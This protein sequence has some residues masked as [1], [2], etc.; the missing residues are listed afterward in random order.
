MGLKLSSTLMW[1][2]PEESVSSL[3]GSFLSLPPQAV[4]NA[5]NKIVIW[6]CLSFMESIRFSGFIAPVEPEDR[7]EYAGAT[8]N[9]RQE[10]VKIQFKPKLFVEYEK[11]AGCGPQ[12][13]HREVI[14]CPYVRLVS[15]FL[16]FYIHNLRPEK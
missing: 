11:Y 14:N 9:A 13:T 2:V 8:E 10:A 6:T 7:I 5:N 3:T 15:P 4:S 12:Y 16:L 1:M